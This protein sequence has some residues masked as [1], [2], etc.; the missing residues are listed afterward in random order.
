MIPTTVFALFGTVRSI[1]LELLAL[2]EMEH[3]KVGK[4][5]KETY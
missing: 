5:L 1:W 4:G 2:A 3:L